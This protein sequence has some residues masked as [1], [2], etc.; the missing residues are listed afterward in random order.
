MDKIR[1]G[2]I[3]CGRISDLN[4]LG[5]LKNDNA[6]IVAVC[7]VNEE[8]AEEKAKAWG[9]K[10]VYKNYHDLLKDPEVDAAEIL[11]P[12]HLHAEMTTAAAEAGKHISVQ[13]PMAMNVKEANEMIKAARKAGVKLKIA[14]NFVWYPPFM[15]AKELLE[16]GEIGEPIL[17]R[18]KSGAGR[19]GWEV[20]IEAW[21]WRFDPEKCGGGP[22]IWDDG[23]HLFSL[24]R[25]LMGEVEKVYA[26]I[27]ST[28]ILP[29]VFLDAPAVI[30]WKYKGKGK[31]GMMDGTYSPEMEINSKYYASDNRVEITGSKGYIWVTRCTGQLIDIAPLILYRDRRVTCFDN[32]EKEWEASFINST[33]NFINCILKDEEPRLSGEEGKKVLQFAL[34]VHKSAR[35]HREVAPDS[36]T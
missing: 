8:R 27:D 1:I 32:I 31:Y 12:H 9:A 6:K 33:N 19:N 34:A 17:V 30:M 22:L 4:A 36:I 35:N 14:E 15:K 10:K 13:K 3:G 11:T 20:P 23:Y 28:E 26:W 7:D 2:I 29:G 24:A 18:I 5:Y 16:K 25:F 21:G